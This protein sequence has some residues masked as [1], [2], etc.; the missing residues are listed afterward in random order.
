[1]P[2]ELASST[3]KDSFNDC[4]RAGGSLARSSPMGNARIVLLCDSNLGGS[5]SFLTEDG[6]ADV[7][8]CLDIVIGGILI[9]VGVLMIDSSSSSSSDAVN[10]CLSLDGEDSGDC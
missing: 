1:M 6:D 10:E 5:G 4:S 9:L 7:S 8:C 2:V 3:E